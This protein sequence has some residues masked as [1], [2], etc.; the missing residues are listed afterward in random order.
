MEPLEIPR[1]PA[2][3]PSQAR[4]LR[5]RARLLE[6]TVEALV[7]LGYAGAKTTEIAD[8]AGV[9]QGALYKHFPTKLDLLDEA[10]AHLLSRLRRR[11]DDQFS[12]DPERETDPAGAVFRHMWSVFTSA[13]LQAGFELYLAARTDA[14][15]AER[16][17]P[18][19][20]H[21]RTR[22]SHRARVLFPEAARRDPNFDGAVQ[23]LVSTLQGAAMVGALLPPESE[24]AE[25]QQRSIE[26]M[27]RAE[28]GRM[29][30]TRSP[31]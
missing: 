26:R 9:S 28:F 18:V 6:A 14:A 1:T 23:A 8:R 21:H 29:T 25:I 30:P 10:L 13:E 7:E 22:I 19:I 31:E 16:V 24:L 5:T 17:V 2:R 20:E 11:F 27:V 12:S 15:L 3:R 4:S